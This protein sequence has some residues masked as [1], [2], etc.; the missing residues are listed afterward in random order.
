MLEKSHEHDYRVDIW[1]IGVLIYEL[2][3]GES[4]FSTELIKTKTITEDLVKNNIKFVIYK[5]PAY[6]SIEVRDLI[7]KILVPKP[8]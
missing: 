1:S 4:P 6:L 5:F 7:S 8:S 2:C 3:T